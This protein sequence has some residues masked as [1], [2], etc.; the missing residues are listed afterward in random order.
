MFQVVF[1]FTLFSKFVIFIRNLDLAGHLK[2]TAGQ[3]ILDPGQGRKLLLL[4]STNLVEE[5]EMRW[6]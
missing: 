6:K 3:E 2:T 4:L 5:S 1:M